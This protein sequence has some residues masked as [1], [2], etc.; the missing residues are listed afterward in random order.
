MEGVINSMTLHRRFIDKFVAYVNL[1]TFRLD[2][3]LQNQI[4]FLTYITYWMW[5]LHFSNVS[6]YLKA[7][8]LLI[9]ILSTHYL[10]AITYALNDF[11][12]YYEDRKLSSDPCK[13]SFY[14]L[15]FIQFYG[16]RLAGFF[17]QLG[18]YVMVLTVI[19]HVMKMLSVDFLILIVTISSFMLVSVVE[20]IFRK[21]TLSKH[22][23]FVLQQILKLFLLS[24][25]LSIV[26]TGSYNFLELVIFFT[27][28]LVYIGYTTLRSMYENF[29]LKLNKLLDD[30]TAHSMLISIFHFFSNNHQVLISLS[31]WLLITVLL[32]YTITS[33]ESPLKILIVAITSHLVVAP[34][35]ILN[36]VLAKMLGVKDRTLYQL[37]KRLM[38]KYLAVIIY[39]ICNLEILED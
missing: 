2:A 27:W 11:I 1:L 23:A 24:Y 26:F 20:S 30:E 29:K 39:Y 14:R 25:I 34:I 38:L 35:W 33:F 18:Y 8:S 9:V 17:I 7:T 32:G 19:L 5:F 6:V 3:F 4:Y 13:F 16:K 28:C 15:R 21:G 12:N 37:L 22:L 31:P 36:L 10:Y